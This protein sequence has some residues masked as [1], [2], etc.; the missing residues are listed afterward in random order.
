MTVCCTVT[1]R[2]L[3]VTPKVSFLICKKGKI[4]DDLSHV[5]A[6]VGEMLLAVLLGRNNE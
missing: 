2:K 6:G 1:F 5:V 4:Q 3:P